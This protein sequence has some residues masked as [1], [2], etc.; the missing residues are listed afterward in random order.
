MQKNQTIDTTRWRKVQLLLQGTEQE[1]ATYAQK[2]KLPRGFQGR[3]FRSNI[4]GE[5]RIA[6]R[7]PS[8]CL[9]VKQQGNILGS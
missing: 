4:W 1:R 2:I 6:A 9:M 5:V 8:D 7:G 3:D